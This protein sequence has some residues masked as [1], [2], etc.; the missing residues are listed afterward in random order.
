[1]TT[2]IPA[3]RPYV[4]RRAPGVGVSGPS[5]RR[6]RKTAFLEGAGEVH[7]DVAV[8]KAVPLGLGP[9]VVGVDAF[10]VL[11]V[12]EDLLDRGGGG[13]ARLLDGVFDRLDA[14]VAERHPPEGEVDLAAE[15]RPDLVHQLL[16]AG[17]VVSA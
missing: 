11:R 8:W 1:M 13:R 10:E 7:H 14:V 16:G 9:G 15:R 2:R 17:W 12:L 4:G 5:L 3:S 6:H